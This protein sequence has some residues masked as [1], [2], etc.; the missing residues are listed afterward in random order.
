MIVRRLAF[1][2]ILIVIQVSIG[3]A[4]NYTG[5]S[6]YF[7]TNGNNEFTVYNRIHFLNHNITDY[8][9]N[10]HAP[11]NFKVTKNTV[12]MTKPTQDNIKNTHLYL[13]PEWHHDRKPTNKPDLPQFIK[14]F[15]EHRAEESDETH[16]VRILFNVN[17]NTSGA[18]IKFNMQSLN[19]YENVSD[20]DMYFYWPLENTSSIYRSSVVLRLYQLEK[21]F[22]NE[23]NDTELDNPDIHKLFNV[24][25]I[26]KAQRGWQTFK[27]KKPIDNWLK[28]DENLGLLLTISDYDENKLISV[29]N[30]TNDGILRTFAVINIQSNDTNDQ[31]TNK[32][33]TK[34]Q[35]TIVPTQ[36]CSRKPWQIDFNQLHWDDFILYPEKSFNAYQCAGKCH[37]NDQDNRVVNYVKLKQWNH[38]RGHR[39]KSCC[40]PTSFSSLPIMFYDRFDNVVMKNYDDMVVDECG[41]R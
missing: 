22:N 35:S 20:A 31:V 21:Q 41:C 33:V 16:T 23:L 13:D 15:Y 37:V 39:E 25:Y 27:I 2:A 32:T 10:P 5:K 19:P 34:R 30:D 12:T 3:E 40:V 14:K 24:I 6:Y 11:Q 17:R 38:V 1:A 29:F 18:V 9:A 28:G 7:K 26:S 8:R 4:L 36:K